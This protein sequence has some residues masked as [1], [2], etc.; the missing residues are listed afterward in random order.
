M[1]ALNEA[2]SDPQTMQQVNSL[3]ASLSAENGGSGGGQTPAPGA[4]AGLLGTQQDKP[5][6][7][8]PPAIPGDMDKIVK[9][10][11]ILQQNSSDDGSVGLILALKP[12]LKPESRPKADRVIKLMRLMNAY[13]LIRDSGL[14]DD[15]F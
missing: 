13:P 14:L 12:L 11:G 8:A 3:L 9:L 5:Q 1:S 15:I 4:L 6:P 2:L 7:A 10:M